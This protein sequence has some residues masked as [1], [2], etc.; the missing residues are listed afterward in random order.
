VRLI[1]WWY[2]RDVEVFLILVAQ[3][4]LGWLFH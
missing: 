2:R 1:D 3:G 4:V